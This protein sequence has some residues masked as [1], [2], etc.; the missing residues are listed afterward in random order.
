MVIRT[1]KG[2]KRSDFGKL[3]RG[4]YAQRVREA[5][6]VV[7]LD[8]Q[9]AKAF[10]N[11]LAVNKALRGLLRDRKSSARPTPSSTGT[12]RERRAGYYNGALDG[13]A[14]DGSRA[15]EN[16]ADSMNRL[17]GWKFATRALAGIYAVLVLGVVAF[18]GLLPGLVLGVVGIV[19]GVV[20]RRRLQRGNEG[21]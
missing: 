5:T 9:V 18:R 21:R 11:D 17:V 7:V 10:P 20:V 4:K 8:P 15:M 2:H 16:R 1:F 19:V 6:N 3:V 13:Q 12:R 14:P